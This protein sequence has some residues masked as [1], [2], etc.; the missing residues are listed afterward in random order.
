[1]ADLPP[2]IKAAHVAA[3]LDRIRYGH[4]RLGEIRR[5]IRWNDDIGVALL[6]AFAR[7][8]ERKPLPADVIREGQRFLCS[9]EFS[10]LHAGD[11]TGPE[12]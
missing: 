10:P 1:M 3:T 2:H 5:A 11:E 7:S 9:S 4:A 6:D 12:V 8:P